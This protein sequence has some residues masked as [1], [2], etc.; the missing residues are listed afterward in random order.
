MSTLETLSLSLLHPHEALDAGTP[1]NDIIR[2][3]LNRCKGGC[4]P[5]WADFEF[6]DFFGWHADM[7]VSVFPDDE[8]DPEMRIIGEE[9]KIASCCKL[10]GARFS[11]M[12]PALYE[13]ELSDHFTRIR[14]E[15]LIGWTVS[16]LVAG[17]SAMITK[18]VLELPVRRGGDEVGG[19]IH[20]MIH[21]LGTRSEA[22]AMA[23]PW[24]QRRG[25]AAGGL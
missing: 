25:M 21:N 12:L 19:L 16:R 8:P 24:R 1:F 10:K 9:V 22:A 15:R 13:S 3:W 14:R 23:A 4:I 5:D 11:Q 17:S 2:L 20:V 18:Q 7:A 6:S